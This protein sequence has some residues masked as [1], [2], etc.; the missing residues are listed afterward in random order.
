MRARPSELKQASSGDRGAGRVQRVRRVRHGA[1][2]ML[3][4]TTSARLRV[5]RR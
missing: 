1:W 2:R 3:G 4:A 5:V